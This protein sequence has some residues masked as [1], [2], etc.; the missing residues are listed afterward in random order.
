MRHPIFVQHLSRLARPKTSSTS[1]DHATPKDENICTRSRP[2]GLGGWTKTPACQPCRHTVRDPPH[3]GQTMITVT[4]TTGPRVDRAIKDQFLHAELDEV[5]RLREESKKDTFKPQIVWRNVLLFTALHVGA[6]V[7]AYQLVFVA[8]WQTVVW[9][10]VGWVL[11]G[12]GITAGAH[13]LWAHRSYKAKWPLRVILMILQSMAFQNDVIEWSRDH[14]CHHKWTDTDADPHN[15]NRGFFFSHMGW[16][17]V[18][19][20]PKITEKGKKLDLSDLF[21]DPIL[22]FQRKYY[23]PLVALSCF[24]LPTWVAVWGWGENALVGLYTVAL[25]RYCWTLHATWFINSAAHRFGYRPYDVNITPVESVWTTVAALGEGGHNYHH[26]FPQDY[27]ASEWELS[28][29]ITKMFIDA[30]AKIGWAYDMKVVQNEVIARQKN[31][32]VE[33]L[34]ARA[35][36][37]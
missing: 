6:L 16:L 19:K 13:R 4:Q 35:K 20:H 18:R 7:G 32:Q 26:T 11:S 8:K 28:M 1:C 33:I 2:A 5:V 22:T 34:K 10:F 9:T 37:A 15:V 31:K 21:N 27:R 24:L 12:L 17:L 23:L 36:A 25:F 3:L 29:N 30:F 14:R